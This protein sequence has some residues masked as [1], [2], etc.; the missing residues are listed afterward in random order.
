MAKYKIRIKEI[1]GSNGNLRM[2]LAIY[3]EDLPETTEEEKIIPEQ[4]DELTKEVIAVSY[5]EI[6]NIPRVEVNKVLN[7]SHNAPNDY[8]EDQ[9]K[10][11]LEN[12]KIGEKDISEK[13]EYFKNKVF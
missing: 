11:E 6:V 8:I 1:S 4:I 7:I 5:T 3:D 13:I 12:F 9:I 10:K 2:S